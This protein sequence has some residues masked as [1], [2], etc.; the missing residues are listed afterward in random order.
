MN[1]DFSSSYTGSDSS[2]SDSGDMMFDK[3]EKAAMLAAMHGMDHGGSFGMPSKGARSEFGTNM[4]RGTS[5]AK[6]SY[7]EDDVLLNDV[8]ESAL[9]ARRPAS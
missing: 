9:L 8:D 3:G 1:D 5:V 6:E 2:G 7:M 4:S